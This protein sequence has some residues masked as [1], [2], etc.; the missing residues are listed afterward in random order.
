MNVARY[1]VRMVGEKSY[2][3]FGCRAATEHRGN[4]LGARNKRKNVFVG[5]LRRAERRKLDCPAW[6][7][8][9]IRETLS[10]EQV[11]TCETTS[12]IKERETVMNNYSAP[13]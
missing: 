7:A 2:I 6:Q 5:S 1:I 13:V 11:T 4:T 8:E 3:R 9:L 10:K 12:G